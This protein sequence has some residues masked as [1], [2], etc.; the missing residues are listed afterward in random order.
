MNYQNDVIYV[1]LCKV[2]QFDESSYYNCV[3]QTMLS[4]MQGFGALLAS[5]KEE[6][7]LSK[8]VAIQSKRE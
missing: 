1:M 6:V 7:N 2:V 8:A 5:C 3:W 4:S